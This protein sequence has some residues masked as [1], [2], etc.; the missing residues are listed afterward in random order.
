MSKSEVSDKELKGVSGGVN[1]TYVQPKKKRSF[2]ARLLDF[3]AGKKAD[4]HESAIADMST[5]DTS[6]DLNKSPKAARDAA[7]KKA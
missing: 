4:T 6:I 3:F 7:M 2:F 1:L 5:V